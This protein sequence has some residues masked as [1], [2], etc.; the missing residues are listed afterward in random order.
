MDYP[1]YKVKNKKFILWCVLLIAVVACFGCFWLRAQATQEGVGYRTVTVIEVNGVVTVVKGDIEYSAYPGM[2]LQEGHVLVTAGGGSARLALDGDKYV[3]VES[4]SRVLFETLGFLGSGKTALRLER[5]AL[6]SEIVKPLRSGEE[7]VVNTPNAVLAVRG[8]FFRVELETFRNGEI[9][10]NVLT[11]GGQVAT[12]RVFPSGEIEEAEA[13]VDAGFKTAINMDKDTTMYVVEKTET[14][15][16]TNGD[17]QLNAE[18]I[19]K[20]DIS[21]D[22][23]V[24]LYYASE[25]GHELFVTT[26]EIE[27]DI[28]EREIDIQGTTS[29]YQ[30]DLSVKS[31]SGE[32]NQGRIV[33]DDS[34]P[35]SVVPVKEEETTGKEDVEEN[36][37][38]LLPQNGFVSDGLLEEE[39][40][41]VHIHIEVEEKIEPTCTEDGYRIVHCRE[42]GEELAK[43]SLPAPG[44]VIESSRV[45]ATCTEHGAM[46]EFCN[47]CGKTLAEYM[48]V[49][50]GHEGTVE[51]TPVTCTVNGRETETC[52]VCGE[53]LSETVIEAEGHISS[54]ERTPA[55]CTENGLE[56][57]TCT[58]CGEVLSEIILEAKGHTNSVTRVEGTCQ[59]EGY[60]RIT[61]NDCGALLSQTTLPMG[62]HREQLVGEEFVHSE[63]AYCGITLETTHTFADTVI[64]GLTCTRDGITH[65]ECE[66]GYGYD[67]TVTASG[68]TRDN[69]GDL[70]CSTCGELWAVLDS[71]YFP[72][73][74]FL[75]YVSRYDSD[76]DGHLTGSEL[77]GVTTLELSGTSTQDG[78]YS[79]LTG[80][81]YF[82]NLTTLNC[83]YNA[84]ITSLELQDNSS[85]QTLN[86]YNTSLSW[87]TLSDQGAIRSINV[88]ACPIQELILEGYTSLASLNVGNCTSLE[89]LNIGN[90]A[91]TTLDTSTLEALAWLDVSGTLLTVLDAPNMAQLVELN[92]S[93]CR[94]LTT[95]SAE[96]CDLLGS[97]NV[98]NCTALT[99]VSLIGCASLTQIDVST[100][101][102]LYEL[103]MASS[104]VTALDVTG[105][106]SLYMLG[107]ED[108]LSLTSVDL[109]GCTALYSASFARSTQL[110]TV[111]A[112]GN[113]GMYEL[114]LSDCTGLT[115]VDVTGCGSGMGNFVLYAG[116]TNKTSDFFAG[117]DSGYMMFQNS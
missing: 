87:L 93:G 57:E 39:N 100:C 83:S 20:A 24:D 61:C 30:K 50:K 85:L 115:G 47:V 108:C 72:D 99:N 70:I 33:P 14:A 69:P 9:K 65:Y 48:L 2:L 34:A 76:A 55:T 5:G 95:L 116:G 91:V 52:S 10:A 86:C 79:D 84:G 38:I 90:T 40:V 3:K 13:L 110:S 53:I 36:T 114:R 77:T 94:A 28:A 27:E 82:A 26:E 17:G 105:L 6:T 88:F 96:G 89:M 73:A 58:V 62:E 19:H 68:H 41:T 63:C 113:T 45:E 67:D 7:F 4:G 71:S 106:T 51:R 21:D 104:G 102:Q 11:Y 56:T 37:Q 75:A 49:P 111:N 23:L 81:K 92:A 64:Q 117:Y 54:V 59:A 1:N 80:I 15:V 42:C 29:V 18:P 74:A 31:E 66:C 78:G 101:T 16:D 109:S 98:T 8:T 112:S 43:E 107:A 60:E 25:N 103:N 35:L 46:T 12:K 22:D 44:H 97:V 32:I